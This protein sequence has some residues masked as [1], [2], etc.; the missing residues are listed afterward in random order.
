MNVNSHFALCLGVPI[1]GLGPL[2]RDRKDPRRSLGMWAQRRGCGKLCEATVIDVDFQIS[3]MCYVC[4]IF[5]DK[6]LVC[7]IYVHFYVQN[8]CYT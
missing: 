7:L 5:W 6:I 4:C 2:D 8:V 1:K 3:C